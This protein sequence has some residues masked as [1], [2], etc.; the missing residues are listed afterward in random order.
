MK[1]ELQIPQIGEKK[2]LMSL[3]LKNARF[4]LDEL[5]LQRMKRNEKISYSVQI[6]QKDL[7]LKFPPRR[8]EAFDISNLHGKGRG[9][10]H[11]LFPGWIRE[12]ERIPPFQNSGQRYP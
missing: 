2:K 8:I 9:G 11:G 3:C 10:L 1:V 7:N 12:K 6:L 5:I 4:L